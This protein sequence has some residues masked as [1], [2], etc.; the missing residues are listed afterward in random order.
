MTLKTK[1]Y[2]KLPGTRKGFLFG[3][4]T[5]WQGADHILHVYSRLGVEDYKRFYFNDIQSVIIRKTPVGQFQNALLGCFALLFMLMTLTLDGGWSVFCGVVAGIMMV[6]LLVNFFRGPT[7]ET[8]LMT[9]VQTEK[10]HSLHRLKNTFKAMD[11]LRHDIHRVQGT[12]T[13]EDL[14]TIAARRLHNK[15]P[16]ARFQ[17]LGS[18]TLS[19][20]HEKGR[21]HLILFAVLLIDGVLVALGFLLTH[22]ALTILSAVTGICMGIFVTIA[23]VRQYDSDMTG[24]LRAITW[25]SLGFIAIMFVAGYA[26]SVAL[27]LK[28]PGI[29]YNQW[30]VFKLISTL[31]PWENSLKLG[32]DIFTICGTFII[33]VTGLIMLKRSRSRIKKIRDV[34]TVTIH[35]PPISQNL[36]PG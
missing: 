23:L 24:S 25:C 13:R 29:V 28:N 32:F 11:R 16:E 4:Y 1:E 35:P 27:A 33:G 6:F 10:I 7:C 2:Q 19:R 34:R 26:F 8:K 14:E 3:K 22:V 18:Q 20:K 21:A 30:E 17:T 5:L 36:E 12:L 31:S 15:V 9:A